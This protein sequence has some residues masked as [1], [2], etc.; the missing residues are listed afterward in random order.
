MANPD[1]FRRETRAWLEKNAPAIAR[2]PVPSTEDLCWGG[3]KTVYDPGVKQWLDVMAE[4]GWTAPTWPK[5]TAAAA[6]T[7][8]RRASSAR[9]WRASGCVRR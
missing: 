1:V 5:G 3:R 6:S 2:E 8:R 9:R 7:S 4:R